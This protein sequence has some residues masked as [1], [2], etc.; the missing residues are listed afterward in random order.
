[1]VLLIPEATSITEVIT[2]HMLLGEVSPSRFSRSSR[3]LSLMSLYK[4]YP[5]TCGWV[6][7]I[8]SYIGVLGRGFLPFPACVS[9]AAM[10]D[11]EE[12]EDDG[13]EVEPT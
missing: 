13:L 1:M 10:A 8:L 7:W 9:S 12:L 2:Y 6:Q 4:I 5:L 11:V 3:F